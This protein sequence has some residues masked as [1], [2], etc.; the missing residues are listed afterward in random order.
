MNEKVSRGN[1]DWKGRNK[2]SQFTLLST[3]SQ[4]IDPKQKKTNPLQMPR[5]NK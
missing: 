4:G 2:L 3:K 1:T 5:A